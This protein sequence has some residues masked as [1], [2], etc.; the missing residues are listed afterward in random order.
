MRRDTF[1]LEFLTEQF[2]LY[3]RTASRHT[4]SVVFRTWVIEGKGKR[5]AHTNA[6]GCGREDR[7]EDSGKR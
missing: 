3:A 4:G 1:V 5:Y 7:G 2:P 6:I